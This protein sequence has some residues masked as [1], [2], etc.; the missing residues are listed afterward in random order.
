VTA[1]S[2]NI[3]LLVLFTNNKSLE[4]EI[5][6][7]SLFSR[8]GDGGIRPLPRDGGVV[9]LHEDPTFHELVTHHMHAPLSLQVIFL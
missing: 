3:M 1:W 2:L 9:K 5:L 8:T 6:N 4:L 7:F